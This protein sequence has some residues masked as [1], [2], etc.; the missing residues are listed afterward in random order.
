MAI[1]VYICGP[2]TGRP[3]DNRPAFNRMES[4]LDMA[5]VLPVSPVNLPRG[6]PY[7]IYM[8]IDLILVMASHLLVLLPGHQDSPGANDEKAM[9][10]CLGITTLEWDP[11]WGYSG[12]SE[13]I[14]AALSHTQTVCKA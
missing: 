3:Y 12:L 11:A 8:Q 14:T 2:M 6:L 4:L 1:R 9:A 7:P 5:G 10:A 13:A